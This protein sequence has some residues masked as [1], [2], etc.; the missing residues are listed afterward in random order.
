MYNSSNQTLFFK[1]FFPLLFIFGFGASFLAN[2]F[3]GE[4]PDNFKNA[5]AVVFIWFLL[6]Y[7]QMPFRLKIISTSDSGIIIK[8]RERKLIPYSDIESVSK[9]DLAGPMFMTI[10]YFDQKS[11]DTKKICFLPSHSQ[12]RTM[13]DDKIT[14]YI[15][16]KMKDENPKYREENQPS[17]TKNF[18]ILM[19]VSLPFS[20]TAFSF[21]IF[22]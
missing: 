13:A 10:K 19:L 15:K 17:N 22:G 16:K 7:A 1:Y 5:F 4:A 14:A 20:V 21:F 12:K 11:G 2:N 3:V 6:I 9:Y 8:G 18:F